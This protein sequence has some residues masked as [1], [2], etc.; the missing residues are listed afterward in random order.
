M[1]RG[2]WAVRVPATAVV[3][4]L[5][6]GSAGCGGGDG[7]GSPDGGRA[8][9][10]ASAGAGLSV[11]EA[12]ERL[13]EEMDA[14]CPEGSD[15]NDHMTEVADRAGVLRRA[16]EREDPGRYAEPIG[17]LRRAGAEAERAGTELI[18]AIGNTRRVM[19]P[20]IEVEG[21]MARNP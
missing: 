1:G 8:G 11:D 10:S 20:L 6:V 18:G 9:S 21:W 16:M 7:G 12:Y 17:L 13:R 19:R 3:V 5:V 4:V 14:G 2:R 15:C